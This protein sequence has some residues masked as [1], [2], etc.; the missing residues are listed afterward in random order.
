M[1]NSPRFA[2]FGTP[3]FS[4]RIL[5]ILES[6][7]LTPSVLISAPDKPR[8]RGQRL[9]PTPVKKWALEHN[10]P[11]LTPK[12]L[13]N[14]NDFYTALKSFNLDVSVVAAYG[15]IIPESILSIPRLESIN[16]HPS[17]L[18]KYRGASPIESQILADESEIGVTIMKMD[19]E[20]DHGPILTS[21]TIQKPNQIPD[22]LELEK[23][24]ANAGGELLSETLIDYAEGKIEPKEQHH[25]EATYTT[26]IEKKD[27][28]ID[29]S[30]DPYQNFLKI[31]AYKR[32]RPHF[33]I[34]ENGKAKRFI[35]TK[36]SFNT[37]N[38]SLNIE[39]VIPEG[40]KEILYKQTG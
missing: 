3:E 39:R 24:L 35:I 15:L 4:V 33:Y 30:G 11:T 23:V 31:Q 19:K 38:H 27:T 10:L 7:G 20:L 36:A 17:L 18:P 1:I 5:T 21:V 34:S 40:G 25:D 22:A 32:F 26:K 16:V 9:A 6:H 29:L 13:K 28:E 14:N 8:G 12:S 2:F 37:K